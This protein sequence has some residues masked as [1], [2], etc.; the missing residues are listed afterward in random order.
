MRKVWCLTPLCLLLGCQPSAPPGMVWVPG[1]EF[2]MGGDTSDAKGDERPPHRVRVGGF[3]MDATEVTNAQFRAFVEATSY[4]TTAERA[5][6]LDEIMKQLPPATPP[7]PPDALVPG[8]LVFEPPPD[9]SLDMHP[10]TWWRYVP[11][12]DWRH[13][14]GPDSSIEGKDDHPVVQV[15]FDDALAYAH[16]AGKRLPTEAEWERAARGG[17]DDMPYVWGNERIPPGCDHAPANLWDGEFPQKN[18]LRDGFARSAPVR[19]YPPNPFGLYDMAGNV[20]EW[21][22]DWYRP[23][24]YAER[25]RASDTAVDPKGPPASFDPDEPTVPKRVTRGG[26]FLCSDVYCRGFRPSARMKTS[27]DTGLCHTGFRCVQDG[28]R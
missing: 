1:G 14:F 27:A 18:L 16:W 12:A 23:D 17:T 24:T 5:P 26:S 20:W 13:P 10:H 15:S 19:S 4:V 21:C 11:G 22:A 3:F 8:A 9:A 25:A 7:P 6:E 2:T 28:P